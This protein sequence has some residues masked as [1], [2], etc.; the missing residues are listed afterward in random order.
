MIKN[1]IQ[2]LISA[3]ENFWLLLILT[4]S[5]NDYLTGDKITYQIYNTMD[6]TNEWPTKNITG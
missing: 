3:Q 5:R 2:K 6:R 4:K 1:E